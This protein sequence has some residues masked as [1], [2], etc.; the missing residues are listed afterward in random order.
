MKLSD[1]YCI[2]EN[3]DLDDYLNLYKY[4]KDNIFETI[5]G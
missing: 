3:V 2:N 1:L 4:V 5:M